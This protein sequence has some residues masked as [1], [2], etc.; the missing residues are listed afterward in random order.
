M[1]VKV[2]RQANKIALLGAPTSAAA[3]SL[4][5]EEGP[6]ALRAA[7]LTERLNSIG[8]VVSDLG[9]D[10]PQPVSYTHL[11]VYKRQPCHLSSPMAS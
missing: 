5:H 3:M 1:A 6:A 2:V 7:G 9:D 8:Y 4:G 10:P 11:D